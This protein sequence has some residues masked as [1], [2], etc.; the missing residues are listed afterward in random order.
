MAE[1]KFD[2]ELLEE[3]FAFLK[4]LNEKTQDKIIYNIDKA[5]FSN[6][7][8]LFKKLR[9]D[10]WEFRTL[11]A[12]LQ[13]RFFAFWDKSKPVKTLVVATH[14]AIKKTDK[15]PD[16]EINKA[17]ELRKQYLEQNSKPKRYEK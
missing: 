11:Y 17:I 10:I 5:R 1:A 2:I 3:A 14:G 9:G 12:G 6:D 13:Y 15:V 8:K 7:P 4:S 16:N